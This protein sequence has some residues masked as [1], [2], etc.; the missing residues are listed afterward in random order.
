MKLLIVTQTL[1]ANDPGLG[2]FHSWVAALAPK[3][4][5]I[6]VIALG[7]G[8]Y[9]LPTNVRVHSLGKEKGRQNAFSYAT[10]FI[11]LAW[12]LRGEYD[13]VLVHMNQEYILLTGWLWK[14]LGKR[15]YMWRNHSAGSML[16]DIAALLCDKI[17]CTS[18]R[19]Y[20]AQFKKT[21]IMPVGIDTELFKPAPVIRKPNSILYLG[22][23]APVKR[24]E[25]LLEAVKRLTQEGVSC[26]VSLYGNAIPRNAAYFAALKGFVSANGLEGKVEFLSGIKNNETPTIYSAHHIFVNLSPSGLFDK[27][28]LEAAACGTLLAT[29]HEVLKPVIGPGAFA[30]SDAASLAESLRKLLSLSPEKAAEEGKR[31][32]DYVIQNHSLNLLVRRLSE[33]VV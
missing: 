7:V 24:P 16:T 13:A 1:D 33:E 17:F 9:T 11:S 23:I 31:L 22:R 29:S 19:S 25:I 8:A 14:V 6:N 28:M 32:R 27:T 12:S 4:E 3:F 30:E 26:S 21:V 5:T 18:P 15:I 10:R 20:T 2:F